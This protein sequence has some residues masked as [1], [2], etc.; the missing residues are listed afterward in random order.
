MHAATDHQ[1]TS[2]GNDRM[3]LLDE[4]SL[5]IVVAR[6]QDGVWYISA[7]GVADGVTQTRDEAILKMT[8]HALAHKKTAL[9]AEAFAQLM[10]DNDN[11]GGEGFSTFV[12]HAVR[13]LP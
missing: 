11:P 10:V 3:S 8:E 9:G 4:K 1:I 6:R 5:P 2:Q 13:D 7:D 12:P